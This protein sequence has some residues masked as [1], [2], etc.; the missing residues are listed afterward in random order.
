MRGCA[1]SILALLC[2]Y[3]YG[4]GISIGTGPTFRFLNSHSGGGVLNLQY[5]IREKWIAELDYFAEQK[6][7]DRLITVKSYP[8]LTLSHRWSADREMTRLPPFF[9]AGLSFKEAQSCHS[10]DPQVVAM[11][12]CNA[13]VPAAVS[14]TFGIG[15]TTKR[16]E[17]VLRHTSNAGLSKPNGGQESLVFKYRF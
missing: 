11:L 10:S 7:H 9:Q 6:I 4:D 1:F 3:A 15:F 17:C 14:F 2:S 8:M 16:F 5:A 12:N 13:L